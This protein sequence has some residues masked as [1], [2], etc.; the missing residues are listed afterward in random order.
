LW[1]SLKEIEMKKH[2]HHDLI[3][4]WAAGAVIQNAASL[5]GDWQDCPDPL[6]V[7]DWHYRVKPKPIIVEKNLV[8]VKSTFNDQ[9]FIYLGVP[10]WVNKKDIVESIMFC[11]D[12]DTGAMSFNKI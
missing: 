4:Q 11:Y 2:V 7:P 12:C 9:H 5:K 3:V 10:E 1:L 8:V 6:W